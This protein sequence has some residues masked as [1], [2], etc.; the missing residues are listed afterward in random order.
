M[1][2]FIFPI[3]CFGKIYSS[4]N[5]SSTFHYE[6]KYLFIKI[7]IILVRIQQGIFFSTIF[8]RIWNIKYFEDPSV[9]RPHVQFSWENI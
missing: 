3:N 4:K 8:E 7:P 1:R 9:L 5:N 2:F 6:Y